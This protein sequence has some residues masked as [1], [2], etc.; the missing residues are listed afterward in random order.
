MMPV[1]HVSSAASTEP[2]NTEK[3]GARPGPWTRGGQYFSL[4]FP[5]LSSFS[6]HL[7]THKSLGVA[8]KVGVSAARE[9]QSLSGRPDPSRV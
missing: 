9:S 5:T 1:P 4:E 3:T 6:Q 8:G 7:I 2:R